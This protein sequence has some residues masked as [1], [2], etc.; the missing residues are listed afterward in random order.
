MIAIV[1]NMSVLQVPNLHS[2]AAKCNG[3]AV[4]CRTVCA[5]VALFSIAFLPIGAAAQ[6]SSADDTLPSP[7]PNERRVVDSVKFLTGAALG[8][9]V[10]EGGHVLFDTVFDASPQIKGVRFGPVPFFAITHRRSEE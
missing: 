4:L 1:S 8:L 2:S 5:A 7:P 10:H 6:S 3:C 9:A